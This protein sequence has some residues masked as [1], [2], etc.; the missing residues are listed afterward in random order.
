L[1][2]EVP[3]S[4]PAGAVASSPDVHVLQPL[5][6]PPE[7]PLDAGEEPLLDVSPPELEAPLDWNPCTF[8]T[9]VALQPVAPAPTVAPATRSPSAHGTARKEWR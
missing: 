9:A 1:P 2:D 3:P 7:N 5:P 8:G 4:S 6:L